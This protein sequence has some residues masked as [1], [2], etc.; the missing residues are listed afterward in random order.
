MRM[1]LQEKFKSYFEAD[2]MST[3]RVLIAEDRQNWMDMHTDIVRENFSGVSVDKVTQG[4]DL[5]RLATA[6]PYDVIITDN[7]M[8]DSITGEMAIGKIREA[9]YSAPIYMV[10]SCRP[11]TEQ[12]VRSYENTYFMDKDSFDSD[13]FTS[14]LEKFLC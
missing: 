12:K 4:A 2:L 14:D 10:A 1:F 3:K 5:L 9:G 11:E 6:Q 7:T 8:D 13:K